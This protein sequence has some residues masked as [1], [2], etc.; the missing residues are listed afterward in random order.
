MELPP[1]RDALSRQLDNISTEEHAAGRPLLSA[2]VVHQDAGVL[3]VPGGGFFTLSR[4][5]GLLRGRAGAN[6]LFYFVAELRR[7]HEAHQ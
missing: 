6:D 7:V 1:D 3:T 2:V 4:R 5:L